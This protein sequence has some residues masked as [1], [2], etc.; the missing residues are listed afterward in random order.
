[1][2]MNKRIMFL[3][4]LGSVFLSLGLYYRFFDPVH[5]DISYEYLGIGTWSAGIVYFTVYQKYREVVLFMMGLLV[6]HAGVLMLLRDLTNP[7]LLGA[8]VFTAGI[9]IVLSSGLSD[10]MNKRKSKRKY[11]HVPYK[12]N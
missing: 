2:N 9:I 10:I 6:L 1:M 4:L 11:M 8:L 12:H 5:S 3:G 7:K